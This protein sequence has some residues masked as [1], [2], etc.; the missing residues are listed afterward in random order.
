MIY[1]INFLIYSIVIDTN[2]FKA[3][4]I[5]SRKSSVDR[6]GYLSMSPYLTGKNV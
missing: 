1:A 2:R 4:T 5:F 6:A 3:W